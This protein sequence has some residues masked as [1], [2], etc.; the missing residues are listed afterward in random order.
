MTK[1]LL[2]SGAATLA[3]LLGNTSPADAQN[4][5]RW[6][7]QG[8][9][10]TFDPHAQN[11][12]PTNTQN[13]Q[14][15]ESLILRRADQ[16]L[17]PG[18]AVAWEPVE[19]TTWRFQLREDVVFHDGADFTAEDV[20]FSFQRA[21]AES[22]D[23]T[24]YITSVG[25]VEAV[26]DY[27][28][29]IHTVGPNPILPQQ[30][31]E[32]SMVDKDWAEANG[33]EVPQDYA[34]GEETYAVRN[35]N[36]TGPFRLTLREPDVRT[37]MVRND[38]WW[39][40]EQDPHN[41][42]EI[43]YTPIQNAATR[44]AAL[45]S[46]E[47]DF[48]LD[49]PLQDLARI[50]STAGLK[51]ISTPQIRSIFFGL[52]QASDDLRY[53]D[54]NPFKDVRV[55]QAIYQATDVEA[56]RSRIMRGLSAPAGTIAPPGVHG[57]SEELDSRLAFD[58]EAAKALMAEAGYADGFSTTLHCPNDRYINDE[59]IC[60]AMVAM[61]AQL[62]I[63]VNLQAQPN[64]IHFQE[65]QNGEHDFYML[66]WGVPTL[67]SHYIFNFLYKGDGSW[68]FT[69][70]DNERVNALT[71]EIEATI[72]LDER[73]AMIAEA[74]DIVQRDIVYVPLH[75]QVIT[76]AMKDTLELPIEPQDAPQFRWARLAE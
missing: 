75:H 8:D 29:L 55:R 63:T 25:E 35:A 9:A 38:D 11:H 70:Y 4:T 40:L 20:V 67:D 60:Q 5:L 18:L 3:L 71:A 74:W 73:D 68:N 43:V 47:V 61:L 24:G 30:L 22:S 31:T 34:G 15:Y 7:S 21:Q 12:G 27:T 32:L 14:V 69:G 37:V 59:A 51:T 52:D 26:D 49:P 28:V 65:L 44:I 10:L 58:L 72:D 53:T 23:F 41:I 1:R 19:P 66:G 17:E 46:G 2:L 39:G 6:A 36:G 48:V 13:K 33:V 64:S 42:D 50:E 56:I 76:W 54:G 62:G 16:S 45:L 57:Y